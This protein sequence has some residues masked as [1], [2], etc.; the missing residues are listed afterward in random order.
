MSPSN[1][2]SI[3]TQLDLDSIWNGVQGFGCQSIDRW[4]HFRQANLSINL[5]PT[6]KQ[7]TS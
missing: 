1:Q 3:H 4:K 5:K 2:P 7:I 6:M